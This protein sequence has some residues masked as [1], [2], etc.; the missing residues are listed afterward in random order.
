MSEKKKKKKHPDQQPQQNQ[1]QDSGTEFFTSDVDQ[2]GETEGSQSHAASDEGVNITAID[3]SSESESTNVQHSS[4]TE[5]QP[6]AAEGND[7]EIAKSDSAQG[8]TEAERHELSKDE[9]KAK[10]KKEKKSSDR[11]KQE[12][13]VLNAEDGKQSGDQSA[14]S[15]GKFAQAFKKTMDETTSLFAADGDDGKKK[16]FRITVALKLFSIIFICIIGSVAV[17]GL[18]SMV[19]TNNIIE[20]TS[21]T[22][23][24]ETIRQASEKIDSVLSVYE[25]ILMQ[26]TS[27]SELYRN[28]FIANATDRTVTERSRAQENV[29]AIMSEYSMSNINIV[30]IA[31]IPVDPDLRHFTLAIATGATY[32]RNEAWFQNVVNKSQNVWLDTR[33]GGYSGIQDRPLFALARKVTSN[34]ANNRQDFVFLIEITQKVLNDQV[35][36]IKLSDSSK[37]YITNANNQLLHGDNNNVILSQADVQRPSD[38]R[39]TLKGKDGKTHLVVS[40]LSNKTG[41]YVVGTAP[42]SELTK[43]TKTIW[44]SVILILIVSMLVGAVLS[45]V[46]ARSVAKPLKKLQMLMKEGATGNLNVRTQFRNRDEI[47]L[48]GQS[49]NEMMEQIKH[50]VQQTNHSAGEVLATAQQLSVSA[51]ETA[52]AA[53]EISEATE[54]IASGAS[55]LASEAERGNELVMNL[56]NQLEQVVQAN[57]LM[58]EVATDVHKA[59][60]QGTSYMAQLT[61]KTQQTEEMTRRMVEKV[62]QLQESTE[63]IRNLLDMLTQITQQTN[64][65]ALNA[66][67]EASRSGAAGK[68]FMVIAG[69]IRKLA[70]QS[71]ESIK[72]VAEITEHI[73]GSIGETVK[74][75]SEAYPLFQEQIESVKD[76]ENLFINVRDRMTGLVQQSDKVTE[77]I[78]QLEKAQQVLSDTMSSVSA[79]SEESSAISEE[80]ASSSA[81]QLSTSDKLVQLVEK[82]EALSGSL[83]ESLKKFKV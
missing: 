52:Q 63:S 60:E 59:S 35:T 36:G 31:A 74:V 56:S 33:L 62:N 2:P 19:V 55:T 28:L 4:D 10:K 45:L 9:E 12:E 26:L 79:V 29:V 47:G 15:K 77:S 58:G 54:Q 24:Y 34:Y 39:G 82:L 69:E 72:V 23:A 22:T 61:Q 65:L 18:I 5:A 17:T 50:L 70:D 81:S 7:P 32:D 38:N 13:N 43:D 21:Q 46:A 76:A 8:L 73:Q 53:R 66:S 3:Q 41:W 80:V 37:V 40:H 25:Q 78:E 64:I 49:F 57:R 68:G 30:N 6:P 42:M 48:V 11:K 83:S 1:A 16:G 75:M 20:K 71:R 27:N 51:N 67:I 44:Q 14:Q